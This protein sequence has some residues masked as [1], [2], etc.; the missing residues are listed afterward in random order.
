MLLYYFY[1]DFSFCSG[2]GQKLYNNLFDERK[3]MK[4]ILATSI[5]AL[6]ITVAVLA[7]EEKDQTRTIV[8][9]DRVGFVVSNGKAWQK[10][11][12]QS[13]IIYLMGIEE[14]L[15]L[16]VLDASR[17]ESTQTKE[18]AKKVA[19]RLSISGFK[20]S[21]LTQQVNK[22]YSD[23]ANLRVP[24]I[25]VYAYVIRKMKGDSAQQLS[26]TETLLRKTY[27]MEDIEPGAAANSHP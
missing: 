4:R 25:E 26:E 19:D 6:S 17:N 8:P 13:R 27:N 11:D 7:Q 18:A 9:I 3:K 15:R 14:G 24:V 2:K 21:D 22:F 16:A 10:L 5:F 1:L 20:F 23:S 12:L